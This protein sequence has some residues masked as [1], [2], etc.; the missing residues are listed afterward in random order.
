MNLMERADFLVG[1]ERELDRSLPERG[2]TLLSA[3]RHLCIGGGG[4][5][6]RPMLVQIFGEL[7]GVGD[8]AALLD[9][10]VAAELIHSASLLHDDVVDGGM[11]RRGRATV[12]ARWGN[13][14][15]VM[16]G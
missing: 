2:D 10:A 9:M 6:A 15:A 8:D 4:K 5:R 16:S 14:V 13:T 11:Q 12:N 7:A 1:V 3:A